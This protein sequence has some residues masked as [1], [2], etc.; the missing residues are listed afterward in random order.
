MMCGQPERL[1]ECERIRSRF[2][3]RIRQ[4]SGQCLRIDNKK[5]LDRVRSAFTHAMYWRRPV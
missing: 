2:K 5:A 3:E 1:F 4:H